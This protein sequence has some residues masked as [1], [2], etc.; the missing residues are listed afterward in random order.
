MHFEMT[1]SVYCSTQIHIIFRL[2]LI[3]HN[4]LVYEHSQVV[5][6]VA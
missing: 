1:T 2:A 4:L 6:D 5:S 3:I